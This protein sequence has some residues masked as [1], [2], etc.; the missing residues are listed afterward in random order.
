MPVGAPL[1]HNAAYNRDDAM[2]SRRVA[3]AKLRYTA[4]MESLYSRLRDT[5]QRLDAEPLLHA[6]ASGPLAGRLALVSSFGT[7]SAVLLHMVAG[8]AP[9]LPVLFLDTGM[10]FEETLD[11]R[12]RLIARLGLTNVQTLGPDPAEHGK[13]DPE[14]ALWIDNADACCDLRKVRPLDRALA[15][16][17]A[18]ISGLKRHHGGSREAVRTIEF[19][20]GRV[21]LNPLAHWDAERIAGYFRAHDLPRHPLT[22]KGF[23]SV[24]CVPCTRY[25]R[26]GEQLRD[27]RWSGREKTECG[28][29]KTL[30]KQTA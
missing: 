1:A 16:F 12:D 6:A 22:D 15:G 18:W 13:E 20:D 23:P 9:N 10:L 2:R 8:V 27:G 11:Y 30:W 19:E 21:K 14:D 5:Y 28:I 3:H 29:H 26:P 7:E 4:T 25:V 24:G 17:D